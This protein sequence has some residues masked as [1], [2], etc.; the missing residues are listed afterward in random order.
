M[1]EAIMPEFQTQL[2]AGLAEVTAALRA[3]HRELQDQNREREST[4]ALHREAVAAVERMN[5]RS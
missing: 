1:T 5:P 4:R 3:V 2:L